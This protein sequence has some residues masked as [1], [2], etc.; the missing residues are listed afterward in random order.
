MIPQFSFPFPLTHFLCSPTT[1][2]SS[3]KLQRKEK[4]EGRR[5]GKKTR[6]EC[7]PYSILLVTG[8]Q[9]AP[10]FIYFPFFST[11]CACLCVYVC[12]R[13]HVRVLYMYS[14]GLCIETSWQLLVSD[15][16]L[17]LIS[18][19]VVNHLT[20]HVTW[21]FIKRSSSV[22]VRQY[23]SKRMEDTMRKITVTGRSAQLVYQ[24]GVTVVIL[25]HSL[26]CNTRT[27]VT[28]VQSVIFFFF[29]FGQF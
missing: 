18:V 26:L 22:F 6:R 9:R 17:G 21:L 8:Y 25:V 29:F 28:T 2:V 27:S 12:V 11:V 5:K 4:S 3:W 1:S 10:F 14:R 7:K 13:E 19:F 16:H 23:I 24:Q 15:R 20:S